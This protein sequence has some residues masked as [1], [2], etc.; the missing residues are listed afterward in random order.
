MSPGSRGLP[1]RA[2]RCKALLDAVGG[3]SGLASQ[4]F[5]VPGRSHGVLC[6]VRRAEIQGVQRKCRCSGLASTILR[7]ARWEQPRR[8]L[9]SRT[10]AMRLAYEAAHDKLPTQAL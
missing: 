8:A 5:G 10:A 1:G 7:G 6:C 4:A 9:F 2:Q 3:G